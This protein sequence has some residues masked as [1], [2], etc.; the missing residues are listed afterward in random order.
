MVT[1][2]M[3]KNVSQARISCTE[4]L[5]ITLKH[6]WMSGGCEWEISCV[7]NLGP[8]SR[9]SMYAMQNYLQLIICKVLMQSPRHL[10]NG[11]EDYTIIIFCSYIKKIE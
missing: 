2:H 11:K 10:F 7:P 8:L 5:D 6:L 4:D 3:V 9:F 1:R